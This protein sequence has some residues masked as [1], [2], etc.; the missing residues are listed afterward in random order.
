VDGILDASGKYI[1]CYNCKGTKL[2][3][4]GKDALGKQ[5]YQC[6][7]KACGRNFTEQ[8]PDSPSNRIQKRIVLHLLLL[9]FP[10]DKIADE[11]KI[12]LSMVGSFQKKYLPKLEK[13]LNHEKSLTLSVA[14]RY[15]S[16]LEM[17]KRPVRINKNVRKNKPLSKKPSTRMF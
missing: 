1:K 8:S 17:G 11:L 4:N 2:R 9:G 3:K 14:Y 10:A 5:R 7:T 16:A 6:L 12:G 15:V 13:L